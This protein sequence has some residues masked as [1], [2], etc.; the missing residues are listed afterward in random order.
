MPAADV[1]YFSALVYDA[2][3]ALSRLSGDA[4]EGA[5]LGELT[6]YVGDLL[7]ARR[8]AP[9]DDFLS[10]YVSATADMDEVEARAQIV[11][12]ILAGSDTT[13]MAFCST[14]SQLL[15]APDQ[16][17]A[18]TADPEGQKARA[19]EE[20]LRFDP[21]VGSLPRVATEAF[22]FGDILTGHSLYRYYAVPIDR[23]ETPHLD[24][25]YERLQR[26]PAFVEHSMV[27]FEPLR[28]PGA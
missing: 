28:A 15:Q 17:R 20:G 9:G 1:P 4:G 11:A 23:A 25:Y 6:G 12:V 18:L 24:A 3:L 16:W 5:R 26:R 21:V 7:A 14:L 19:A 2:M 10:D 22:S 27:S 13:R 8:R